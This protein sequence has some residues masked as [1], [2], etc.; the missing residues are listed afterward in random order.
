MFKLRSDN[1]LINE[2]AAAAAA[3]VTQG[4]HPDVSE[5]AGR[6]VRRWHRRSFESIRA[7]QDGRRARRHAA[8][9]GRPAPRIDVGQL[10]RDGGHDHVD[11]WQTGL[12]RTSRQDRSASRY[13]CLEMICNVGMG[14]RGIFS[15]GGQIR[16]LGRKVPQQ[17]RGMVTVWGQSPQ[18]PTADSESNA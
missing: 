10:L 3:D 8:C 11:A 12:P 16:G 9:V 13:A 6:L 7:G 5:R 14:A 2:N 17:G 15:R 1:F 4:P 18:K